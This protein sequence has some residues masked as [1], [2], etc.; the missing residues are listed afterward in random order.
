VIEGWL[1]I[2]PQWLG[3]ALRF[4]ASPASALK[5]Y[6]T[7]G[8]ISKDLTLLA[9]GGLAVSYLLILVA[10]PASL[11]QDPSRTLAFL[12]GLEVKV[13]PPTVLLVLVASAVVIHVAARLAALVR[14]RAKAA[15][16]WDAYLGGTV[17]DS[18]NGVLGFAAVYIPVATSLFLPAIGLSGAPGGPM[19]IGAILCVLA[20]VG[21]LFIYL[22][23]A[24]AAAHPGT[25]G[26]QALV[27]FLVAYGGATVLIVAGYRVMR[28]P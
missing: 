22:P 17:E 21:L 1:D 4:P 27:S 9:V 7:P 18:V 20:L 15:G 12:R 13:I 24:L 2:A 28:G 19:P 8:A 6:A 10:A 14:P 11:A 26:T 5:P 16:R 3:F 25:R 23:L